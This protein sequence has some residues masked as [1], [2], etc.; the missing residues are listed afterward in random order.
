MKKFL[1]VFVAIAGAGIVLYAG[2]ALLVTYKSVFGYDPVYAG[3]G[4]LVLLVGGLL[5]RQD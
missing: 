2:A 3:L 5:M 1:A 4:G